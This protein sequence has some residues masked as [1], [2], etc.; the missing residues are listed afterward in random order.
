[1]METE[2]FRV[3]DN[4]DFDIA[5]GA[6]SSG[7]TVTAAGQ[8]TADG[9]IIVDDATDATSTTDGSLQ[10]DGG[11]SVAKDAVIGND[12]KLLSDSA[13][14]SMGAGNDFTIT[15][16]GSTGAT[17]AAGA[18]GINLDMS[19]ASTTNAVITIGD[20]LA[21]SLSFKEGSNQYLSF[22]TTNTS[23]R[24]TA[25]ENL[26]I[27]DD[28]KL[29]FGGNSDA[30]IEYD[31]D[32]TDKLIITA[33]TAG[34]LIDH[35]SSTTTNGDAVVGLHYDFDHGN[36]TLGDGHSLT[37]TGFDI[38]MNDGANAHH[39]NATATMVG[40]DID[41]ASTSA[42]GTIANYGIRANISGGDQNIALEC[43]AGAI[44]MKDSQQIVFGDAFDVALKWDHGGT[45]SLLI[46]ND[47]TIADDKRIYFGSDK[48]AF[49]EYD[50]AD[51]DTLVLGAPNGGIQILD[52]K[53]LK[54]GTNK[55]ASIQYDE[56]GIDS[57]QISANAIPNA[58][59]DAFDANTPVKFANISKINGEI[60]TTLIVDLG[61][62]G[63]NSY[64]ADKK[65]I[66]DNGV[67]GTGGASLTKIESSRNGVVYRV[68]VACVETPGGGEV[69]IDLWS[70]TAS[71]NPD[72]TV[73]GT[74]TSKLLVPANGDWF[75][76]AYEES[77][78]NPTSGT[79]SGA[80]LNDH[81][82]YLAV[83]TSSTPTAG[84]YNAGTFIIKFY[85]ADNY[86]A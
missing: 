78:F 39:A 13:V 43:A 3:E 44:H 55:D 46:D 86:G 12:L 74:G 7:V 32:G 42:Q 59:G 35:D 60:V 25:H 75:A 26:M 62:G 69:D 70:N 83:G 84:A 54:F 8:I 30:T 52:D 40:M 66:G 64:N 20:N 68:T 15:H 41:I 29:V 50:E 21:D 18:S 9:R 56:N 85:G 4:G 28:K 31:E 23:E 33:P 47:V 72:T 11:L 14:F 10:T 1:M 45:E 2:V 76:G 17:I 36:N 67:T 38:D 53:E 58:P 6:G 48:D 37:M 34:M 22:R 49:I 57:L 79:F 63:I 16:D 80:G 19:S 27:A 81:Y 61:V 77:A 73:D 24:I 71:N 5:G 65:V 51:E 82:I